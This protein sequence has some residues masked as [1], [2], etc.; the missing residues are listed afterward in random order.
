LAPAPGRTTFNNHQAEYERDRR[1]DLEVD[2]RLQPDTP[3]A[4]EVRHPGDPGHH[5]AEDDG[6]YDHQDEVDERL[7]DR[8]QR[9]T[10]LGEEVADE[11]AQDDPNQHPEVD[12]LVDGLASTRRLFVSVGVCH[13][14]RE[15]SSIWSF[16]GIIVSVP[17][18][19]QLFFI[20]PYS[21]KCVERLSN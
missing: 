13:L 7:A 6:R 16:R 2:E 8:L 19:E 11:Y 9:L 3:D 1:E 17:I 5:G 4:F 18:F 21:P 15:R 14:L 12:L 20:T 10:R